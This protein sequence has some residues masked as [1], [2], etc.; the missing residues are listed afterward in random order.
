MSTDLQRKDLIILA[1]DTSMKSAVEGLL[2]RKDSLRIREVQFDIYVHPEHDPGCLLR[3]DRFL[4]PYVRQYEHALIL[5]DREG[6]GQDHKPREDLEKLVEDGLEASGWANRAAVVV[7]DPELEIWVWSDSSEV[8]LA[9]GWANRTPK[10]RN[11]LEEQALLAPGGQKPQR[12]KEALQIALKASGKPQ[13]S[14]L[15]SYLASKVSLQRCA[16]PAFEKLKET[17]QVWFPA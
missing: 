10:L 2:F 15:F 3:A 14:S 17:L 13:S 11:W 5:F 9:L 16:D 1:A 12:P 8:D 4:K 7:L 6:C